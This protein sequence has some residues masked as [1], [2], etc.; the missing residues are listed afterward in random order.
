MLKKVAAA[1]AVMASI[2]GT[3]AHANQ[4]NWTVSGVITT[5]PCVLT[6]QGTGDAAFGTLARQ[7]VMSWTKEINPLRHSSMDAG[8]IKS[9]P[10]DV[11]CTSPGKFALFVADNMASTVAGPIGET[12]SF[13][14]GTTSGPTPVNLGRYVVRYNTVQIKATSAAIAAA[15]GKILIVPGQATVGMTGWSAAAGNEAKYLPVGKSIGFGLL[16]AATTPDALAN[17]S[18]KLEIGIEPLV[19]VITDMSSNITL[20]GS[21]TVT[22]ITL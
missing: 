22:L 3:S 11:T 20:T 13:G 19:S 5:A 2:A 18:A 8:L 12:I 10:L 4:A 21:A 15:P 17:V 1:V 14:M 9:V 6:I 16:P 7:T